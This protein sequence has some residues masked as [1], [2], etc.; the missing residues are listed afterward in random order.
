MWPYIWRVSTV[1]AWDYTKAV[2][3]KVVLKRCG[4]FIVGGDKIC[5][6]RQSKTPHDNVV[7][8][9]NA[10]LYFSYSN[11]TSS[12]TLLKLL[13]DKFLEIKHKRSYRTWSTTI[14]RDFT[15]KIIQNRI[16]RTV[17]LVAMRILIGR[18]VVKKVMVIFLP[19]QGLIEL[20]VIV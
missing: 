6:F 12:L 20:G 11:V 13:H 8:N 18:M 9:G 5:E 15:L 3:C 17:E 4:S 1:Q 2:T 14:R 19:A 10:D 7:T 16:I